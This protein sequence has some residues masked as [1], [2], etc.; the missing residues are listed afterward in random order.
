[1]IPLI[2]FTLWA[3]FTTTVN[4]Y[5][6]DSISDIYD[7]RLLQ[8][9]ILMALIAVHLYG[10]QVKAEYV[11]LTFVASVLLMYILYLAGTGVSFVNG[12][13][14]IFGENPNLIGVKAV[15]AFLI[16]LSFLLNEPLNWKLKTMGALL[17]LPFLNLVILSAS[18]GALLSL[19]LGILLMVFT[20]DI[21]FWKKFLLG[22]LGLFF[23]ISFFNFI[24]ETNPYFKKRL[25]TTI[26]TGDIGRND[27]WVAA[28]RIIYENLYLGVG[29]PGDKA[30]MF[31]YSGR[32]IDPHNVFL[33]IL[34]TTGIIGFLFFMI[35]LAR[36][37]FSIF[38]YFRE[39]GRIVFIIVFFIIL[40][41][42]AKAGGGITKIIFWFLFAILIGAS[43]KPQQTYKT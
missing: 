13:I 14:L 1:M 41:N 5:F 6:A 18:R 30:M 39:T 16:V 23:S 42:M 29:L 3:V 22:I 34:M 24:L 21:G 35:F 19:F 9:I 32:F 37:G 27:L 25:L 2:L 15:I 11:L 36:V 12:R 40:L 33:W 4:S 8:L 31:K 43:H 26:E 20:M 17:L 38:Q 7:S 10:G 28:V